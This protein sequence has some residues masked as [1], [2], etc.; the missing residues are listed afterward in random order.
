MNTKT[1][2][3]VRVQGTFVL[4]NLALV[5]NC[6]TLFQISNFAGQVGVKTYRIKRIFANNYAGA[7][8]WLS[9][10]TGLGAVLYAQALPLIRLV[11]NFN[12]II[13]EDDMP[14]VEFAADITGFVDVANCEVQVEVEEVG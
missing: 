5:A 6:F 7:D 9:I 4:M 12:G 8:V 11:N 3:G 2:Q 10:G 1:E 14:D 13:T